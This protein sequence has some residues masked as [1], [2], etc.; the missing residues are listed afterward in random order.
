[1]IGFFVL[2][3][4]KV[5]PKALHPAD[6]RCPGCSSVGTVMLWDN[7]RYFTLFFIP[8]IP[9]GSAG[10]FIHCSKCNSRYAADHMQ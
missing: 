8:L 7:R 1:V 2:F 10:K 3:G 6:V 4:T 5:S 9:I